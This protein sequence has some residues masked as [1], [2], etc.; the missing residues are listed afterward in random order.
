MPFRLEYF[1]CA[2]MLNGKISKLS[3][4]NRI[5]NLL[6]VLLFVMYKNNNKINKENRIVLSLLKSLLLNYFF[7]CKIIFIQLS[8][9]MLEQLHS[10]FLSCN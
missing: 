8:N 3:M 5:L 7:F 2:A 10:S 1:C 6:C 4:M 9:S